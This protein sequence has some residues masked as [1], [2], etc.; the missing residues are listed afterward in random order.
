MMVYVACSIDEDSVVIY[1]VFSTEEKAKEYL[2]KR[3]PATYEEFEYS[4]PVF[5]F[6]MN[7]DE[8]AVDVL[9]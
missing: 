5:K 9:E 3:F 8:Y 6:K 4:Y 7:S 2:R 1:G